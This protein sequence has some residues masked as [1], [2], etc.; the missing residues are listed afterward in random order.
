MNI[1]ERR[2]AFVD[3]KASRL[4]EAAGLQGADADSVRRAVHANYGPLLGQF[5]DNG[6]LAEARAS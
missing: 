6:R 2:H 5:E 3:E 4:I 1:V